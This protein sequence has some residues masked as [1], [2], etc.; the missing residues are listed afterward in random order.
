MTSDRRNATDGAGA[1]GLDLKKRDKNG[2]EPNCPQRRPK[3]F[4][5]PLRDRLAAETSADF[6]IEL[7]IIRADQR[8]RYIYG[9]L[10]RGFY[11]V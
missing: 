4:K 8:E 5:I 2:L 9:W 6:A 1:G 7:G 3:H 10:N 11:R